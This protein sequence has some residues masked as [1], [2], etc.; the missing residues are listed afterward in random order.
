MPRLAPRSN[1]ARIRQRDGM[2]YRHDGVLGSGALPAL[3]G[4]LPQPHARADEPRVDPLT[5]R[6][7]DAGAVL[8]GDLRRVH[9]RCPVRCRPGTS[10]RWG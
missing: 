3:P 4:R 7:D 9:R 5:D 1:E 8:P 2:T 6:F 10:G